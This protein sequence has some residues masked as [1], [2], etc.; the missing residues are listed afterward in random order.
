MAEQKTDSECGDR[1]SRCK[2]PAYVR[3]FCARSNFMFISVKRVCV[4]NYVSQ[5]GFPALQ[6]HCERWAND[7]IVQLGRLYELHRIS[8]KIHGGDLFI[9]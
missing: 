2:Q 8:C 6:K 5:N 9:D 7:Q 1:D 3:V 4:A